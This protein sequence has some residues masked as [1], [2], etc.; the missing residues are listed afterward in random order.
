MTLYIYGGDGC[1]VSHDRR[2][3]IVNS[4]V[5]D[6]LERRPIDRGLYRAG[7]FDHHPVDRAFAPKNQSLQRSTDG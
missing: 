6:L 1:N 2:R 3:S 4:S 5:G 7:Q